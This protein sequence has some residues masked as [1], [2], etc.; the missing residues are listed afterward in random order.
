MME[1]LKNSWWVA[2]IVIVGFGTVVAWR[3]ETRRQARNDQATQERMRT[4]AQD[5]VNRSMSGFRLCPL[6]EPNCNERKP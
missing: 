4:E 2:A 1:K 6:S 3:L 5:S